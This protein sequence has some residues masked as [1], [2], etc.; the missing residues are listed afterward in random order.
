MKEI[1]IKSLQSLEIQYT[2]EKTYIGEIQIKLVVLIHF[3]KSLLVYLKICV[4]IE[5]VKNI[6]CLRT[7]NFP[8]NIN[9]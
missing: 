9:C 2:M 6:W 4:L 1:I 3:A 7:S 5:Y 8:Q